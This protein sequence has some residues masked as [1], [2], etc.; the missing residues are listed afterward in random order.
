[1]GFLTGDRGGISGPQSRSRWLEEEGG[2][3]E[4]AP[5]LQLKGSGRPYLPLMD[6]DRKGFRIREARG[7]Y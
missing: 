1:M 3:G 4:R 2:G 5:S 7:W 6:R